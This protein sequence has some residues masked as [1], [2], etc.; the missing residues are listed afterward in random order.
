ML[1]KNGLS[2]SPS[3]CLSVSLSLCLSWYLVKTQKTDGKRRL[4]QMTAFKD[5]LLLCM[6]K[7]ERRR[8]VAAAGPRGAGARWKSEMTGQPENLRFKR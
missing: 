3:L 6:P 8:D 7:M 5:N 2:V 1:A 4:A